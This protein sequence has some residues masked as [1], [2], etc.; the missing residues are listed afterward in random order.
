MHEDD[1]DATAEDCET[2]L[3]M[4]WSALYLVL[5]FFSFKFKVISRHVNISFPI[6]L[7]LS[8]VGSRVQIFQ[9]TQYFVQS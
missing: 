2:E 7:L 8:T 6:L 9:S 1:A 3:S 5:L 4:I